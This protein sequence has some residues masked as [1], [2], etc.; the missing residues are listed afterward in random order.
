MVGNA[1]LLPNHPNYDE[2]LERGAINIAV[3]EDF[4]PFSYEKDGELVGLDVD[5]GKI[6]AERLGVKAKFRVLTAG[7][8][9][10]DDLRHAIWKGH[11]LGGGISD[12]MMHVPTNREFAKRNE[13]VVIM[14]DYLQQN[15]VLVRDP[16][17]TGD[18]PSLAV[19]RYEKIGVELDSFPDFFLSGFNGGSIRHNV[20]HYFTIEDAAKGLLSGDIS[21]IFASKLQLE[22]A[23]GADLDKYSV[24]ELLAPGLFNERWNIGLAVSANTRQLGYAIDDIMV[25]LVKSGTV[26]ALYKQHQLSYSKPEQE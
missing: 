9:V 13:M 12:L 19:Y 10:E 7:E 11:Y 3:Y 14:G 21:A 6:I 26:E 23:L 8:T 15:L 25:E 5:L 18:T 17:K 16:I 4:P 2:I 20:V 1:E 22:S 24:D